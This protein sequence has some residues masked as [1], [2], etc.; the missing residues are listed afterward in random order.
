MAQKIQIR[1]ANR[2]DAETVGAM[3]FKLLLELF[4]ELTK[5]ISI[6]KTVAD[7]H[8][9]LQQGSKVWAFIAL[10]ESNECIG[11]ITLN[12]CAAIYAGGSFG[13]ISELYIK[14]E[15]RSANIGTL[16]IDTAVE[17]G[18]N[19]GWSCF[20]VGAPDLPKWQKTVD[21]YIRYGFNIVGPR[22]EL[23]I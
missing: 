5:S 23:S 12:E 8:S 11:L 4:P 15:N 2:S 7:A 1:I 17:F 20:E 19:K 3:V 13:E 14:P 10:S 9:L 21:F 22:L 6:E 16:L 18:R